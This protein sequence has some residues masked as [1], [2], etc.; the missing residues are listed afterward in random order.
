MYIMCVTEA[1]DC[2]GQIE[3]D[4]VPAVGDTFR[5]RSQGPY[6]VI[7]RQWQF[8]YDEKDVAKKV[9][10]EVEFVSSGL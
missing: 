9:K 10:L 7:H 2:I 1:G 6:R 5:W 4:H 8:P 3:A